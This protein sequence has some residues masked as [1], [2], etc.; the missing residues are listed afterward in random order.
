MG[1]PFYLFFTIEAVYRPRAAMLIA[2]VRV[3]LLLQCGNAFLPRPHPVTGLVP[4]TQLEMAKGKGKG[5]KPKGPG[6]NSQGKQEPASKQVRRP[7][8]HLTVPLPLQLPIA[9]TKR[10]G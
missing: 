3:V 9:L 5:G 2:L 6:M 4:L 8:K 10:M 7:Y 1:P